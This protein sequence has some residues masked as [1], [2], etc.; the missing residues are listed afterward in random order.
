MAR[1]EPPAYVIPLTTGS[2]TMKSG[3]D[4]S[5]NIP[6]PTNTVTVDWPSITCGDYTVEIVPQITGFVLSS[7]GGALLD[8]LTVK[9]DLVTAPGIYTI[10]IELK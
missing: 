6:A 10:Q 7:S 8:T 5:L 9:K 4:F 2:L 3:S 1:W